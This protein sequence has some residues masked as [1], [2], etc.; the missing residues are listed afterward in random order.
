MRY[1]QKEV[2]NNQ[3]EF[4]FELD[5]DNYTV[6]STWEDYLNGYWIPMSEAQ[7][8][9]SENNPS[10]SIKEIFDM[11]LIV[12]EDPIQSIEEKNN[13]IRQKRQMSYRNESDSLYMSYVKY[14]ELGELEKA[15]AAKSEWLAKVQEI[16]IRF[17]YII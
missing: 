16:D 14:S 12:I 11:K 7:I 8:A 2:I 4:S 1:L 9:F 3:C 13:I 5:S 6:G 15:N 17:P 10:A